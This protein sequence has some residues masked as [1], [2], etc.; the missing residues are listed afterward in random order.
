MRN[1]NKRIPKSMKKFTLFRY[2]FIYHTYLIIF[3][4][5][6]PAMQNFTAQSPVIC[7]PCF[8]RIPFLPSRGLLP[9]SADF[10]VRLKASA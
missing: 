9:L 10:S 3:A 2:P 5:Q 6:K 1:S 7:N 8:P 4:M